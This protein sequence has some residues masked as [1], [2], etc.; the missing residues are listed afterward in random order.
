MATRNWRF[1]KIVFDRG[2]FLNFRIT[3]NLEDQDFILGFAMLGKM[4]H[5]QLGHLHKILYVIHI[6]II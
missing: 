5:Y 3:P 6:T 2:R 1:Y 4:A